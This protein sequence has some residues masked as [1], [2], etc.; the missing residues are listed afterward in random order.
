MIVNIGIHYWDRSRKVSI[1]IFSFMSGFQD[2]PDMIEGDEEEMTLFTSGPTGDS[3]LKEIFSLVPDSTKH[4][5]TPSATSSSGGVDKS[6]R[7]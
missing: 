2:D 6:S 4:L 1:H 5:T 3:L 7:L